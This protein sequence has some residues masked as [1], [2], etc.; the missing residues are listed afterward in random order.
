MHFEQKSML[1]SVTY[2]G[3]DIA[4]LIFF[5]KNQPIKF[6]GRSGIPSERGG[7]KDTRI[8]QPK[9]C[10]VRL[11]RC[12]GFAR[13]SPYSICLALISVLIYFYTTTNHIDGKRGGLGDT[14]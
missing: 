4:K 6:E 8:S 2:K 14:G 13:A 12:G 10:L 7:R 1:G 11:E 9:Y 5:R 3:L